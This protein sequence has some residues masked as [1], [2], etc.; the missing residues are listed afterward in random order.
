MNVLGHDYVAGDEESVPAADPFE[1]LFE[2]IS[3]LRDGEQGV[4]VMA[5]K[6]YE[7][8]TACLLEPLESPGHAAIV[9]EV[10]ELL[11]DL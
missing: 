3:G 5:A 6:G 4:P 10:T 1:G 7:V 11:C 9:V 2:N 8:E